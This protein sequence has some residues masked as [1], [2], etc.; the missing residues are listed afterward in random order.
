MNCFNPEQTDRLTALRGQLEREP[1][2]SLS[3][4][5]NPLDNHLCSIVVDD[6][7]PCLVVRWKGYTTSAQLR[8]ILEHVLRMLRRHRLSRILGDDSAIPVIHAEDQQWIVS[9]WF[10]RAIA[11]GWRVSA[12]RIPTEYFGELTTRTV[13]AEVP[14][15]VVIRSFDELAEA[16]QW[17]RNFA[18]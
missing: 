6:S 2:D 16:R 18:A 11:A 5:R 14:A 1:G 10:P 8:F 3:L 12:N 7:V 15:P 4:L 13:Q 17:L 9:D